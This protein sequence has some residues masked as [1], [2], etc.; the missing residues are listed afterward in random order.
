MVTVVQKTLSHCS[1][2]FQ[3][4]YQLLLFEYSLKVTKAFGLKKVKNAMYTYRFTALYAYG[5][6]KIFVWMAAVGR[7]CYMLCLRI[8]DKK[9]V[10][11]ITDIRVCGYF[12][13]IN[14]HDN[15]YDI[16]RMSI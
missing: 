15:Y 13:F 16:I 5:S 2:L 6:S 1:R 7:P 8:P 4:Y 3:F 12:T 9:T 10:R 11:L 14:Y